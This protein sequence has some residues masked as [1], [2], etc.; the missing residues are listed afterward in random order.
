M[1]RCEY[2]ISTDH[3]ESIRG[4]DVAGDYAPFEE[5]VSGLRPIFGSDGECFWTGSVKNQRI[6]SQPVEPLASVYVVEIQ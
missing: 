1:Y 5:T 4:L 3:S 2:D 6:E